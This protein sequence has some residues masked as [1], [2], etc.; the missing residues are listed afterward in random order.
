MSGA[1]NA[2]AMAPAAPQPTRTRRS[3]RRRPKAPAEPGCE[4]ATRL[5]VGR[6]QTDRGAEAVRDDVL[7]PHH[8]AVGQR[9]AAAIERVGL[10][11]INGRAAATTAPSRGSADRA[12]GRR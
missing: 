8:G 3:A 10:N 1:P 2:A 11:G 12:A 9:Q 5:R 6:L 7:R 4:A